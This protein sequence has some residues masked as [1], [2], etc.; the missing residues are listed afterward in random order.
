MC[1]IYLL[2]DAQRIR[3]S[4]T[5]GKF[6]EM[7]PYQHYSGELV[8]ASKLKDVKGLQYSNGWIIN[9]TQ[10]KSNYISHKLADEACALPTEMSQFI[11]DDDNLI[12]PAIPLPSLPTIAITQ[13]Q[14]CISLF[15]IAQL[16]LL[17]INIATLK[18][19]LSR[20]QN[21]IER[22]TLV[23]AIN[24]Y[25]LE[26]AKMTRPSVQEIQEIS[27]NIHHMPL[28]CETGKCNNVCMCKTVQSVFLYVKDGCNCLMH[29][30]RQL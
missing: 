13:L 23:L 6:S 28:T 27:R 30:K 8:P 4:G 3:K 9:S 24:R 29:T 1:Y 25:V 2:Q 22:E 12:A 19:R 20:I 11:T 7:F 15:N 5:T 14:Y 26:R 17:N 16:T 18:E 10:F 21:P